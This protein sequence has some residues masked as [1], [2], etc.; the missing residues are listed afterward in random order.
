MK[1]ITITL[2]L[3]I[4]GIRCLS[5]SHDDCPLTSVVNDSQIILT[6][7]TTFNLSKIDNVNIHVGKK[8][9]FNDMPL[10]SLV[11]Q[12][13]YFSNTKG[14]DSTMVATK[15]DIKDGNST[16]YHCHGSI[17]LPV[18][19]KSVDATIKGKKIAVEWTTTLEFNNSH[20]IIEKYFISG[21]DSVGK[22]KGRGTTWRTTL[23]TF[24]D[25]SPLEGVNIYRIKQVDYDGKF[26][27]SRYF[28]VN[29]KF[30]VIE[31]EDKLRGYNI[32]G[33]RRNK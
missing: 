17:A 28:G 24:W 18:R 3:L 19:W 23:Y 15:V 27:Y 21:W 26:D 1:K 9:K 29:Y 4:I 20:F 30:D 10:D 22:M 16:I 13:L 2:T 7:D 31:I 14:L 25:S 11:G 33:Q 6:Y 8:R 32:L 5:Q 12:T